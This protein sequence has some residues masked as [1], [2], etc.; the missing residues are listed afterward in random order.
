MS[1]ALPARSG[2]EWVKQGATLFRKQAGVLT[3]LL[4][5]NLMISVVL[6][7]IPF[8]GPMLGVVLIPSLSMA[9]LQ[10]C[11]LIAVD[12]RVNLAVLATGFRKPAVSALCKL[13]LVYLGVSLLLTVLIHFSIDD[14]FMKQFSAPIDPKTGPVINASDLATM[15]GIMLLQ[16]ATVILLCFAAPL[17]A[18]QGM[19][20]GKATFYSFFAVVGATRAFF[21]MLLSWFAIFF[22]VLMIVVM[23]LGNSDMGRVV[24]MWVGL[25]FVLLLQCAIFAAYRQI[26]GAPAVA[27]KPVKV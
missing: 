26:F 12:Q 19:S 16:V 1:A 15:F 2:W 8:I 5:I 25:M 18:W 4:F 24:I 10:A 27:E 9:I 20:A 17:V 13:G 6:G 3:A 23:V 11:A 14:D 7:V 22:L 21:V